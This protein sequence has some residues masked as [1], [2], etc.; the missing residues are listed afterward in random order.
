MKIKMMVYVTELL[1]VTNFILF[2]QKNTNKKKS[3]LSSVAVI[4]FMLMDGRDILK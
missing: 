1:K 4:G 3:T 2:Q